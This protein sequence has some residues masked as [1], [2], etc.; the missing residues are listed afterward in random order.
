MCP[1]VLIQTGQRIAWQGAA[2]APRPCGGGSSLVD[3]WVSFT[4]LLEYLNK[5]FSSLNPLGLYNLN[6]ENLHRSPLAL[7]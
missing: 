4:N 1:G 6:S 7:I 3:G 2:G 5:P